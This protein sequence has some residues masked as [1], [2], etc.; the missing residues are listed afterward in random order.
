[1]EVEIK[2][3]PLQ[4][5][6]N[7]S[8]ADRNTILLIAKV[9]CTIHANETKSI[10]WRVTKIQGDYDISVDYPIGTFFG[11]DQMLVIKQIGVV[12]V[13]NVWVVNNNPNVIT[14]CCKVGSVHSN[15]S[16]K[17]TEITIQVRYE[18]AKKR[19]RDPEN[20]SLRFIKRQRN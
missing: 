11:L 18:G 1:M 3:A 8:D 13:K 7:L 16:H 10:E 6:Q 20:A 17:I 14:L 5:L 2:L 12:L 15:N 19:P 9:M 4:A